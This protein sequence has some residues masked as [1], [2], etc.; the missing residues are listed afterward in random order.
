MDEDLHNIEDLFYSALDDNEEKPSQ[1]VWDG[2]EKRLDKDNIISINK[3]YTNLKRIA[4]LLLLLLGIS[5]YEMDKIHNRNNLAKHNTSDS[6]NQ[7][8]IP[9]II[10]TVSNQKTGNVSG[11]LV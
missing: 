1:N 9:R 2:V 7:K 4:V 3:K 8:K 10:G 11:K 5:I 6:K